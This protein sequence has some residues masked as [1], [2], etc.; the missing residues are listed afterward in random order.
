MLGSNPLFRESI[1]SLIC[2]EMEVEI[3]GRETSIEYALQCIET[4]RPDVIIMDSSDPTF[5]CGKVVTQVLQSAPTIK[6]IGLNL[7]DSSIC[8]YQGEKK[9]AKDV[10]D[11]IG[12]IGT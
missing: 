12:V 9:L 10:K 11:L 1:E 8:V 4:T 5:D 7:H 3:V 2:R 6:V